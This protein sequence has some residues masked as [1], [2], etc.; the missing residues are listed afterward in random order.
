MII[1]TTQ[2]IVCVFSNF[3]LPTF[4]R[5]VLR[6]KNPNQREIQTTE[7]KKPTDTLTR[8]GIMLNGGGGAARF[9]FYFVSTRR[10]II[11]IKL[12]TTTIKGVRKMCKIRVYSTDMHH[13][14]QV[15]ESFSTRIHGREY[16]Y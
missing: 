12:H 10:F 14:R 8:V 4:V 1:I 3:R 9:L 16:Y 6:G 2:S 7:G 15:R 13:T 5:V 11:T